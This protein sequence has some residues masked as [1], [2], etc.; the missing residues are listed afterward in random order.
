MP[1]ADIALQSALR[2]AVQKKTNTHTAKIA[3]V[4]KQ[5]MAKS[6]KLSQPY[7]KHRELTNEL[8]GEKWQNAIGATVLDELNSVAWN[9]ECPKKRVRVTRQCKHSSTTFSTA[10][11][12]ALLAEWEDYN[13][14]G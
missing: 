9:C 5:V 13:N 10:A 1:E 11:S 4:Q 7:A 12:P 3:E 2:E 8:D 6:A 14:L